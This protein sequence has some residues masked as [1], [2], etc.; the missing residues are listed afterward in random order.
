MNRINIK[1]A[2]TK[3]RNEYKQKRLS[4]PLEQK[5]KMD[6]EICKRFLSLSS[7]RYSDTVL[8][9]SPLKGEINTDIILND[10][11][12][13]GKKVAFPRCIENNEMV[14]HYITSKEQLTSGKYGISEPLEDLPLY[15]NE[16]GHS[17]CILPAICYDKR[18]YRLGYGKGY[19]DRFL[20]N[21]KGVKVG[22]IYNDFIID[23]IPSG[24]FDLPSD[25][26]ITEKRV[27]LFAKN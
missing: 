22:L 24:K 8:L 26:V 12:S 14:Y 7:Y 11:L 20:S 4:I 16:I 25:I 15:D 27:I 10:A 2:K 13:K 6:E 5:N 17:I 3:I 9:Y 1:E 18:G 19:Y 21:F 23:E